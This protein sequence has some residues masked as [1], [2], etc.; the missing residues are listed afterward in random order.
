MRLLPTLAIAVVVPLT[1]PAWAGPAF[2][3][4]SDPAWTL[5]PAVVLPLLASLI[6]YVAG[7]GRLW[8]HAGRGRGVKP[9]QVCYFLS[10]WTAVAAALLSP[11][12]LLAERLFTA[13]M[14][15]HEILMA[16]AAPLLVLSRPAGAFAWG[17]PLQWSGAL[18]R[19][20]RRRGVVPLWRRLTEPLTAT[21]LH[22]IAI[23]A[24]H[25]PALFEMALRSEFMHFLQHLS[26]FATAL[27]FW[28]AM[29]CGAQ[30]QRGTAVLDLFLTSMHTGLLGALLTLCPR[31][32]YPAQTAWAPLWGLTPLEDQQLGG[33]VMWVPA[34]FVYLGA[35]LL[36]A[37]IMIRGSTAPAMKVQ[38][39]IPG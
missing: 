5:Q 10:G 16:L 36:L 21:V 22:A 35:A 13:H 28:Q 24:W 8:T 31:L 3:S 23:W 39:A 32:L 25:V 15:E 4:V 14:V 37:A 19:W 33:L 6:L 2:C 38:D 12:H 27:F 20:A 1:G 30:R 29:L 26:F 34:G 17:L 18:G 11:L 9:A 7:I